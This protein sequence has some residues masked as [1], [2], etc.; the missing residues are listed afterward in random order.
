MHTQAAA[1]GTKEQEATNNL[2][3]KFK[4]G[5]PVSLEDTLDVAITAL[6]AVRRT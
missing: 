5:G 4:T 6:Q 2:E 1:A 3:K